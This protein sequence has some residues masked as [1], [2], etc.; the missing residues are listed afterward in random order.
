MNEFGFVLSS[1]LL[2]SISFGIVVSKLFGLPDPRTVGSGNPGATNVMRSGKK[3]AAL[4]TLLGDA[5]KGWLAVWLAQHYGLT[6]EWVCAVAV[7]V[8]LGH[9]YPVFYGFKGGK[10]VATVA[11]I[12]FALSLWLGASVMA[13]WALAFYMWRVSSLSALIAAGFAPA[14]AA[15]YFGFNLVTGTVLILSALLVWRHQSN[16]RKLLDGT[17]AGFKKPKPGDQPPK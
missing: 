13:T 8:F 5:G 4:L 12:L 3:L 17:E 15:S 11:G 14:Y 16:I 1:Y 7:A 10:G 6:T 9:L 2:G